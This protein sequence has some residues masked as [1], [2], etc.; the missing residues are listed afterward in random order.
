[1]NNLLELI[2]IASLEKCIF[3]I[4]IKILLISSKQNISLISLGPALKKQIK[5][6]LSLWFVSK[7]LSLMPLKNWW[8]LHK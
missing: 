4:L 6:Q 2:K 1:M 8:D 7:L 5:S 3:K